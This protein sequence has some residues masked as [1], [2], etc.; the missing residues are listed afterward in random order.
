MTVFTKT[1]HTISGSVDGFVTRHPFF[2][3]GV[4]LTVAIPLAVFTFDMV[5]W[6][7]SEG[8]ITQFIASTGLVLIALIPLYYTNRKKQNA[9]AEDIKQIK[10]EVKNDH[11]TNLR[12]EGD[13]RHRENVARFDAQEEANKEILEAIKGLAKDIRGLR[14]DDGRQDDRIFRIEEHVFRPTQKETT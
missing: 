8:I 12:V 13:E 3:G 5:D 2:T 14:E 11:S 6:I 4:I 9:T 10:H 1:I 7:P